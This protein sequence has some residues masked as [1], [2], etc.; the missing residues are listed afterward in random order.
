MSLTK[1]C[2]YHGTLP[3]PN[4]YTWLG[5]D[6]AARSESVNNHTRIALN[7]WLE[8][9]SLPVSGLPREARLVFTL[10]GK[11]EEALGGGVCELGWASLQL[12]DSDL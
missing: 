3:L 12:F 2:I 4:F 5:T 11:A 9:K 6:F 1:V 10:L 7:S 8:A